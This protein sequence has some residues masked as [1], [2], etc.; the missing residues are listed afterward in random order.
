V[1]ED[2]EEE[3]RLENVEQVFI[4]AHGWSQNNGKKGKQSVSAEQLDR[5]QRLLNNR[6][7][8]LAETEVQKVKDIWSTTKQQRQSLYRYWLYRYVDHLRG[9]VDSEDHTIFNR[10]CSPRSP[11]RTV[12]QVHRLLA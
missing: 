5:L 7:A 9:T 11:W 10:R 1:E 12:D 3:R 6:E 4:P 8:I 2:E